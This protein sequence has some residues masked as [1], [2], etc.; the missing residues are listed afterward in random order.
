MRFEYGTKEIEYL[1]QKDEKMRAVIEAVGLVEREIDPDLF[2][3]VVHHIIGQ[4]I[5]TKAQATIWKRMRDDLGMV[6]METILEAGEEKLQSFGIT[7]RKAGYITDF[8]M[9]I[10]SNEFDLEGIWEKSDQQ[11]IEELASLKGI[12]V[13]TA[14]MILLFCMQRPNVF[15]FD[16]LAIQR[17]LRMVYHHRKIDRKLFEKYRRRFSPYC[18]VA[19]LYLWAVAGG[20][21]EGMKDY[22]P[23]KKSR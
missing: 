19:S 21:I 9:K 12:G 15:S 16:D 18:S 11:A 13:W 2:S 7:F 20:A 6:N 5:S 14:E 23:K 10:R 22:A 4:Q 8:A 1:K 3:S 17:G